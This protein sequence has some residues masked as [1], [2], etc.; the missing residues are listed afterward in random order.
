MN[1]SQLLAPPSRLAP[2]S[3][4]PPPALSSCQLAGQTRLTKLVA[5]SRQLRDHQQHQAALVC[6]CER[7]ARARDPSR[8][9]RPGVSSTYIVDI[10]LRP[11]NSRHTD[12]A[13]ARAQASAPLELL[14]LLLVG[15]WAPWPP[16][17]L[18]RRLAGWPA[19]RLAGSPARP[20]ARLIIRWAAN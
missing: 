1:R 16:G 14:L 12:V 17:W 18:A 2:P 19:R 11:R 15:W 5:A 10:G 6:L 9:W 4:P 20:L 8:D 13:L 7:Q 3:P